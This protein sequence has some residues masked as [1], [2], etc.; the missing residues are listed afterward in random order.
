MDFGAI[1]SIVLIALGL[2]G[3][4]AVIR[5]VDIA[6]RF[7][8]P[9][10]LE[11]DGFSR[12]T[13]ELI[14]MDEFQR[15]AATKSLAAAP[16]LKA[17][18]QK[19]MSLVLAETLKMAELVAAVQTQFG[20]GPDEMT[21]TIFVEQGQAKALISGSN[22]KSG[23]FQQVIV[24]RTGESLVDLLRR[25][26]DVGAANIAPYLTALYLVQR[27]A[28]DRKF[29]DAEALIAYARSLLAPTPLN[30]ERARFDN[31]LG[32][33]A[34]FSNDVP[35]AHAHFETAIG[36]DPRGSVAII[37]AAFTDILLADYQTASD[38]LEK[39]LREAPP[40]NE[41]LLMTAYM[42][43]AAAK[44][45]TNN[46]KAAEE[47]LAKAARA[48]PFG[49]AIFDVWSSTKE[50]LGDAEGAAELQRKGQENAARFENYAEIASLYFQLS[51]EA[52]GSVLRSRFSNPVVASFR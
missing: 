18:R 12:N 7:E 47:L 28:A 15:V 1:A 32:I 50:A 8:V 4:D 36:S 41:V 24:Q 34:L 22:Q 35:A 16:T 2:L 44:R 3:T 10:S 6:V 19:S 42:T 45:G 31:L 23:I 14:F 33:I 46:L 38:R 20:I 48:Y 43:W 40:A 37:N 13:A 11:K 25:A 29:Q 52:G 21:V 26:A 30:P 5:P 49:R 51:W 39:M 17:D 27:N 9:P